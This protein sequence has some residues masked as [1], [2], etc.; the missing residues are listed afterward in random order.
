MNLLQVNFSDNFKK[1]YKKRVSPNFSLET[2]YKERFQ[3]FVAD[4]QNA[5]LKDHALTGKLSGFRAFSITGDVRVVYFPE[6][7]GIVTFVN[8]GSHNQIYS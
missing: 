5:I 4:R 1:Y 8:I 7:E 2:K 6:A 3:L